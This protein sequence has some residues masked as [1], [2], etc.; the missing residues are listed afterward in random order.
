MFF[1]IFLSMIFALGGS[2]SYLF[3][4]GSPQTATSR[5]ESLGFDS[6]QEITDDYM[7]H[8]RPDPE[9]PRPI[10]EISGLSPQTSVP[11]LEETTHDFI[12]DMIKIEIPGHPHAFNASIV[13]WNHSLVM[14]FREIFDPEETQQTMIGIVFL[15]EY[16]APIGDVQFLNPQICSEGLEDAR[17]VTV[18]EDLY[19]VYSA[20]PQNITLDAIDDL[21][22]GNSGGNCRMYLSKLLFEGDRFSVSETEYIAEFDDENPGK[23]EKNWVPFNFNGELL[24]AYSLAPHKIVS[25]LWGHQKCRTIESSESIIR[26]DFG[27]LRGGT[28][29]ILDGDRYISFFHSSVEMQTAHSFNESIL[30][31]FM[32]AYVY[33]SEPPFKITHMSPEPIVGKGFY[34]GEIYE[35]YWNKP[36]RVIFPWG[37]IVDGDDLWVSCGRQ[38]HEILVLKIDK[39]KLSDSLIPVK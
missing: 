23:P 13:K 15:D 26:W 11:N 29:A 19:L 6:E 27:E 25:P 9:N 33:S 12:T 38:D 3:L 24:L 20:A 7:G 18:E 39:Q 21:P 37:L 28:P 8:L 30:H 10:N 5:S 22:G 2:F 31:Y 35:P 1:L 14:C 17:L 36:V 4:Y 16:F 34:E 32:G